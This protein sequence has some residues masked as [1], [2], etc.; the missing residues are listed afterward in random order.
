[1]SKQQRVNEEF[2]KMIDESIL[3]R[4]KNDVDVDKRVRTFPE[5][6]KMMTKAPT[7]KELKLELETIP[8]EKDLKKFRRNDFI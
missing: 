1:M 2:K 7:F 8:L 5:M 6:T 4:F 3:N